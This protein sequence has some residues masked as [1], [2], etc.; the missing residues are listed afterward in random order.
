MFPAAEVLAPKDG[1]KYESMGAEEGP[2]LVLVKSWESS[3][4]LL[5]FWM[6]E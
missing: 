3:L 6:C 2:E 4:S 1:G 5:A